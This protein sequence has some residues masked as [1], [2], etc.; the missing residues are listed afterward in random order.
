MDGMA[1]RVYNNDDGHEIPGTN[2]SYGSVIHVTKI[3]VCVCVCVFLTT[4]LDAF[5]LC[6]FFCQNANQVWYE[7]QQRCSGMEA[8]SMDLFQVENFDI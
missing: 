7:R 3:C 5:V 2:Q 6:V 8:E 4:C 1:Y